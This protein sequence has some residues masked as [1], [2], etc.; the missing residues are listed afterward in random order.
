MTALLGS[1][2]C[3][4]RC[5]GRR[6]GQVTTGSFSCCSEARRSVSSGRSHDEGR[7]SVAQARASWPTPPV[8]GSGTPR[9]CRH[10]PRPRRRSTTNA[11]MA[12]RIRSCI[13]HHRIARSGCLGSKLFASVCRIRSR[14]AERPLTRQA[15]RPARVG[16]GRVVGDCPGV[17]SSLCSRRPDL[18]RRSTRTIPC[19]VHSMRDEGMPSTH[20]GARPR[21]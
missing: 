14:P 5:C 10:Q 13:G 15:C 1:Y 18:S 17:T 3:V 19:R 20:P 4:R 12:V 21:A 7:A 16:Q 9:A 2:R 6:R 8:P 11:F